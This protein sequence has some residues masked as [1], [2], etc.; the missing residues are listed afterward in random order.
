MQSLL[1][2][3]R[4][5]RL[6]HENRY[7]DDTI[8][9]G[10]ARMLDFWQADA[11]AENIS[12]EIIKA[13]VLALQ[14]YGNLSPSLRAKLLKSLWGDIKTQYPELTQQ[15]KVNES[16]FQNQNTS[17][18]LET[19][20]H[21]HALKVFLCHSSN[22]KPH[23]RQLYKRLKLD[24]YD[25]WLDEEKLI[26]GQNWR[27]EIPKAV[28]NSDVVI[29]CLSRNSITKEGYVQKEITYALDL[30]DEKPDSVI[31]LIPL[32]LEECSVPEKLS[33]WHWVDYFEESGYNKLLSALKLRAETI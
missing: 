15:K 29:V 19:P 11:R 33:R 16:L 3:R 17:T 24:Q 32:K 18:I 27:L 26:P 22:D 25:P 20:K 30:A 10:L 28:R 1:K 8:V 2:L 31:F 14:S 7:N 21:T 6:E 12:E 9:G 5:F 4:F 23:V 13:V